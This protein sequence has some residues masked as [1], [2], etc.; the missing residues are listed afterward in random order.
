MADVA[1]GILVVAKAP[2]AG[3]AKT[4]L[5]SFYGPTVAADLAA[6]SLLDTLESARGARVATRIVALAGDLSQARRGNEITSML[7]DFT[8]VRQ[9]GADFATR[10]RE[11]HF[12]AGAVAGGPV[13][14]IGMD[15]PQASA[16][17]LT[18]A[19]ATLAKPEVDAVLGLA[20]D[21]G[22]WALGL[23]DPAAASV[24]KG[25]AM[26]RADTGSMTLAA[27]VGMG[28]LVTELPVL[29]DVDTPDDV[30]L[31]AKS[32]GTASHFRQAVER[33]GASVLM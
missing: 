20:Q 24:L 28:S 27:L 12:D 23:S 6:A 4:R 21:G 8:V 25:V 10:L 33:A 7:D 11:A 22:W 26:S 14:Q 9:R 16:V 5:A 31:V 30:W 18:A 32:L 17:D 19:A 13:L 29:A 1:C 2:V 3:Q 15:T